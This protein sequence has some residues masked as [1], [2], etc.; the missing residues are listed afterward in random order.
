MQ[1]ETKIYFVNKNISNRE[2]MRIKTHIDFIINYGSI[3]IWF[4]W[5]LN[6]R[7]VIRICDVI[8][9]KNSHYQSHKINVVQLISKSFLKNDILKISQNDFTKFIEIESDRDEKLFKL[10]STEIFIVYLSN[11]E[12]MKK[13]INKN[14]KEYLPSSISSSLKEE[15]IL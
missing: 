3:N 4:I 5:I 1:Y 7:K 15:N 6:Q 2:K 11:D 8:F 13:A 14:D 12:E 10:T 9:D